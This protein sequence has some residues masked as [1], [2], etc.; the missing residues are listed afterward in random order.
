MKLAQRAGIIAFALWLP[1]PAI[2]GEAVPIAEDPV[3]EQRMIALSEDLRCLVCQNE[4][5]A[6]S[7]S[8]LAQD[9]RQEIRDQLRTGK[10][11]DQVIEYLT[12][13]YGDFVLYK[14]PLK[15]LTWLLWFG[16]FVLLVGAGGG[17]FLY[18]KRRGERIAGESLSE[19]EKKRVEAL[20]G[21]NGNKS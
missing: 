7:R 16:P 3:L 19:E 2:A 15:P 10:S 13:R 14:P 12:D 4:S 1:L 20:L 11:N 6:G 9:L 18:L 8:E 21:N 17:F 5:L